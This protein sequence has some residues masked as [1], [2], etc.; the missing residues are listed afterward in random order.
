MGFSSWGALSDERRGLKFP[1]TFATGYC[2]RSHS[3]IQDPHDSWPYFIV[4]FE[5]GFPFIAGILCG[6]PSLTTG[7]VSNLLVHLLLGLPSA[8]TLGSKF[9]RTRDHI[10]L[11]HLRL[12][13]LSVAS[14]ASQG[15]GGSIL[16][17]LGTSWWSLAISTNLPIFSGWRTL[18]TRWM[19]GWVCP[20]VVM[21]DM[22]REFVTLPRLEVWPLGGPA[23]RQ[24]L[25]RLSYIGSNEYCGTVAYHECAHCLPYMTVS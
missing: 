25:Y 4:S 18:G 12:G 7:R 3:R 11:S 14:Y 22:K 13:S 6:A 16:P 20:T 17:Y 1:R 9:H 15:Y 8:V 5:T 24:S 10:T 23:C 21:D 19:G 2:Q